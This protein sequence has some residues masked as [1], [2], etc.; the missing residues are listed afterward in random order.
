MF[1]ELNNMGMPAK[2]KFDQTKKDQLERSKIIKQLVAAGSADTKVLSDLRPISEE[3][4]EA[5]KEEEIRKFAEERKA[6]LAQEGNRPPINDPRALAAIKIEL[7]DEEVEAQAKAT[8]E[9]E[10]K[11]LAT[12]PMS[13]KT[14]IIK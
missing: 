8:A 12:P 11:M 10:K 7:T 1:N 9:W 6:F 13:N 5:F 2:D 4:V 3:E 14:S